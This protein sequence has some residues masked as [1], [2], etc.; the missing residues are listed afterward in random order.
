[1]KY[2]S[3]C[4][5]CFALMFSSVV[6]ASPVNINM[7]SADEMA[8]SLNGIGLSKAQAIVEYRKKNGQFKN[9]SDIVMVRGIG[10]STFQKNKSDILL[11]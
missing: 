10:E 6:F 8:Q 4:A 9:A 1:M 5:P 7:A 11:K 2:T 3:L